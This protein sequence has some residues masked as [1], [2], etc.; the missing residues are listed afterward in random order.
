MI[1]SFA[2]NVNPGRII[3]A[4]GALAQTG[5]E[6]SRLGCKRA[7]VLTTLAQ[8]EAGERLAAQLGPLAVGLFPGAVMHTP[9][10]VTKA[11]LRMVAEVQADAVVALGGGSTIGLGKAIASRTCLPHIAIATTYA[12][13]EVTPILGETENGLKVTKHVPQ[14]L[15]RAVIY[16]PTLTTGLPVAT[17]ITSGLNAM[18]HAIEG[19]YAK[20]RNPISSL[21][22]VEGIRALHRALPTL[23]TAPTDLAARGDALY[24]AW[25]CGTVLGVVGMALHHKLCHTLGGS[26]DL[27]HAETHAVILPHAVA[28]NQF[29][30]QAELAPLTS[31]FGQD[32]AGGL[33]DF[34][35]GLDAPT[36]LR[37]LGVSE[38]D[39]DRAA[40][41]A[42]LNPY[43]NPQPVEHVR[44]RRLLQ[45]AWEGV[46][47][48][49]ESGE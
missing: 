26:F 28:Y 23:I 19:L 18:A 9:V 31:I 17:S 44:L 33:Y 47:P 30:A 35:V 49:P 16:D 21:Q 24:G 29:A 20:D 39:L 7:V 42:T 6:L 45:A 36:S 15:P 22:A 5:A 38:A 11:A 1:H 3:F 32:I 13:S 37:A 34:V 46:R 40:D 10:D 8:K 43:W 2:Y 25:L 12:G 27:P 41:I 48:G 4:A 14:I